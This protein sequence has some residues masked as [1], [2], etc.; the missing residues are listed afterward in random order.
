[1][2]NFPQFVNAMKSSQN[3][4]QFFV[5]TARSVPQ[6]AQVMKMMQGKST[7]EFKSI[8]ENMAHER[9]TTLEQVIADM[10]FKLNK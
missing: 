8:V 6:V 4:M 1:M 9:G 7:A 10:G 5:Q 3:P 2:M